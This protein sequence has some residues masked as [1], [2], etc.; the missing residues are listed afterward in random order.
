M[1][2]IFEIKK[3]FP[4]VHKPRPYGELRQFFIAAEEDVW[5]YAPSLPTDGFVPEHT[6]DPETQQNKHER[7]KLYICV[8]CAVRQRSL[9]PEVETA[10]EAAIRRFAM[11]NTQTTPSQRRCCAAH[12]SNTL[13]F[14]VRQLLIAHC[15]DVCSYLK[16]LLTFNISWSLSP[17]LP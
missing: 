4:N 17:Q 13:E 15:S 12:R 7:Q 11:L 3:C 14:W 2:A 10:S 16:R 1:Q 6:P 8:I 9:S 5:D